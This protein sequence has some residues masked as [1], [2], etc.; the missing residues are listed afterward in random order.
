MEWNDVFIPFTRNYSM[1]LSQYLTYLTNMTT[2]LNNLSPTVEFRVTTKK[3][4]FPIV[5]SLEATKIASR[6][7]NPV[8]GPIYLMG[9]RCSPLTLLLPV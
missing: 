8:I 2:L 6:E 9:K 5:V 7:Y 1:R 3:L 4:G